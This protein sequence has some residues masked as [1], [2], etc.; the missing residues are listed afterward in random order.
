MTAKHRALTA[1]LAAI[2]PYGFV[3]GADEAEQTQLEEIVVSAPRVEDW[4]PFA[5]GADGE[6]IA[7]MRSFT[8]DTAS[9]LRDMPG[10][11]LYGAGGVSSLPAIHGLADDRLRIKVDGMDLIAA[12]PNH[13]NPPLSYIDPSNIGSIQVFAGITPVSIGGDSIGGTIVVETPPPLFAPSG[14]GS[15]AKGEIG[16]FYRGNG[17]ALGGNLSVTYATDVFSVTYVGV[18]AV[19]D[20]YKAG[21]NFKTFTATGRPGHILSLD[22]VGSSAYKTRNH[23]LNLAAKL[24]DDDLLEAKLGYQDI[25][26][27]L[28]PNQRMDM[29]DNTEIRFNLRYFGKRDWGTLEARVY[30][31]TVDHHMDFG[32]DKQ[33]Q[34]GFAPGMPMD[35]ESRN[36]GAALK[37]SLD[38]TSKDTLRA[39]GEYQRYRLD[40]RWPPSPAILPPGYTFGGMAPNTFWNINDGQRDRAALFSEW[41]SHIGEKWLTQLGARYERVQ[42]DAGQ[43]Q[44]YNDMMAGYAASASEFNARDRDK[45]DHNLDLTALGRYTPGA[46]RTFEFGVARKVRSPNLYER[47]AW[48]KHSM[49]M[50]MVNFAGDGNGYVGDMGLKPEK[51][52]TVAATFDWHTPD[53][54]WALQVTPYYTHVTDYI[55][56]RLCEGSGTDMN[57]LCGGVA[58]KGAGKFVHLQFANQSARLYGVDLFGHLPLAKTG[59]GEFGLKGLVNYT[60]GE[61][62]DTHDDLY[63]V[64]PLNGKFML[65]QKLGGWD[66]GVELVLVKAKDQVSNVRNEI[67]TPGYTLVNLRSGYVWKQVRIDFGVENLFDRFYYLPLGGAYLGQGA[68]MSFNREVGDIGA[69]GG[70]ETLWGLGVP[71]MGRSIYAGLTLK[72]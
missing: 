35:T 28:Y 39:G 18:S 56:A 42:M 1:F 58:N 62:L 21:G 23:A 30:H 27:E 7:A 22:E 53:R 4:K 17:S 52:H 54:S 34:Y 41:E 20:N 40:D 5:T 68:T 19:S 48:S 31:E 61:N 24:G 57:A 47:Y 14:K 11:S 66:N 70:S 63:N 8:S 51:A 29:L 65:T 9:L 38:L 3:L 33:F 64:M 32:D 50:E 49:A 10:V 37:A 13:M 26:Y 72:F 36:T 43:V 44:G 16:S 12:C 46:T 45:T 71:G 69:N 2:M 59:A 25:P 15:L 67:K 6:D 55:D 60:N